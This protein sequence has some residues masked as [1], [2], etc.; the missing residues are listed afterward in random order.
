MWRGHSL[1]LRSGQACPRSLNST[2]EIAGYAEEVVSKDRF[3]DP[4]ALRPLRTLRLILE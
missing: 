2:A 1:R 4:F 3:N